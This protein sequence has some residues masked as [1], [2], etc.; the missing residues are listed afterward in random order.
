MTAATAT[1]RRDGDALVFAGALSRDAVRGLWAAL[2]PQRDG[3]RRL[4]LRAVTSIDSAGLA[5]LALLAGAGGV[6]VDGTPPGLAELRSAYRL[7]PSLTFAS[8]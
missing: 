6:S 1:V 3:V 8:A 4:D 5:L 7:S 2:A